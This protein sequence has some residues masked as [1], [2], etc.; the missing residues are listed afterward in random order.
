MQRSILL[1]T[2]ATTK[3]NIEL[4]KAVEL[5]TSEFNHLFGMKGT[6]A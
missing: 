2:F 3:K 4:A 1:Q 6:S 5:A